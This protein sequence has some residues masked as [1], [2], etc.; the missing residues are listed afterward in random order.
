MTLAFCAA[1]SLKVLLSMFHLL[2]NSRVKY[3]KLFATTVEMDAAFQT[4][5]S[6]RGFLEAVPAPFT[7]LNGMVTILISNIITLPHLTV[8][9]F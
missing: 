1:V 7:G 8:Y 9:T 6:H 2:I 3:A 5:L 4:R